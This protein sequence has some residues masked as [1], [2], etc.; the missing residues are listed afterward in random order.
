MKNINKY[1]LKIVGGF[2]LIS[3]ITP[4][5]LYIKF[6]ND[7]ISFLEINHSLGGSINPYT[8]R[9]MDNAV[10]FF[11]FLLF[12]V[13][14][15]CFFPKI[16]DVLQHALIK[17]KFIVLNDS[18][19]LPTEYSKL[20]WAS[21]FFGIIP[22]IWAIE[23][24]FPVSSPHYHLVEEDGLFETLTIII[25]GISL[26]Y[27]GRE[28]GT[29]FKGRNKNRQAKV[30]IIFLSG[31]FFAV[32]IFM[33]E[34]LSWGQR[35]F[36]WATSDTVF[37]DNY[38]KETNVHNFFNPYFTSLY[39]WLRRFIFFLILVSLW[40]DYD[41]RKK[42]IVNFLLPHPFMIGLAFFILITSHHEA[43]EELVALFILFYSLR[44]RHVMPSLFEN[45]KVI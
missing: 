37:M 45:K 28:I 1:W 21:I 5:T 36:G 38:Q 31:L 18:V 32:F 41:E 3:G 43:V 39:L 4:L 8:I 11:S 10:G 6:R 33:M 12:F 14:P 2:L 7:I 15:L 17:I 35:I 44:L 27:L 9:V 20:F 19:T 24:L 26:I 40:L 16:K 13:A 42:Q 30:I 25:L 34:E 23:P 22:T 29:L